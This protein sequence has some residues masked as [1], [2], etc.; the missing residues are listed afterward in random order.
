MLKFDAHADAWDLEMQLAGERYVAAAAL[1]DATNAKSQ[2]VVGRYDGSLA[3]YDV[4]ANADKL[5][6]KPVRKVAGAHRGWV[7]DLVA[8][9]DGRKLASVLGVSKSPPLCCR[10]ACVTPSGFVNEIEISYSPAATPTW[11]L[12]ARSAPSD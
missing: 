7:R 2:L 3:W 6:E 12:A 10:A 5:N 9:D 4:A 11:I 8:F 1:V